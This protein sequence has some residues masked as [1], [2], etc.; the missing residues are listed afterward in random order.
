M[1][2]LHLCH[3]LKNPSCVLATLNL[4]NNQLSGVSMS[5]LTEALLKNT[6]LTTMNLGQ[7]VLGVNFYFLKNVN[8]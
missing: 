3:A 4:W 8:R 7:N 5:C 1:G 6:R 2:L